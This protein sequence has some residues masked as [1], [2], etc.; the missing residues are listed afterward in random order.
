MRVPAVV[1]ALGGNM[2]TT[3]A[4]VAVLAAAVVAAPRY[5]ATSLLIISG[6]T[7]L[8]PVHRAL[9]GRSQRL[10]FD[11]LQEIAG[12]TAAQG[13]SE[14]VLVF[15]DGQHQ[16]ARVGRRVAQAGQRVDA[17]DTGQVV[18]EQDDVGKQVVGFAQRLAGIRRVAH[19]L[20]LRIA[21]EKRDQSAPEQGVVVDDEECG[22]APRRWARELIPL[23]SPGR[24]PRPSDW[25]SAARR[26]RP[27]C[28]HPKRKLRRLPHPG[29]VPAPS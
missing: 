1:T 26:G 7:M 29:V 12:R 4:F 6:A 9:D 16:D 11:G 24:S 19:D 25:H 21:R 27:R 28:P 15:A 18:V 17:S 22:S 2:T 3:P 8:S 23:Y 5:A 10:A 20:Q 13:S 14:V